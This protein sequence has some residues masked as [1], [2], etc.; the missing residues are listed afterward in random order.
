[1]R[2]DYV[3]YGPTGF[4]ESYIMCLPTDT[5]KDEARNHLMRNKAVIL[6]TDVVSGK[7]TL[8]DLARK[9]VPLENT[10]YLFSVGG[11][12]ER[13]LRRMIENIDLY[14]S[15]DSEDKSRLEYSMVTVSDKTY[16]CELYE[17]LLWRYSE[18]TKV[19]ALVT[20]GIDTQ[21]LEGNYKS[22]HVLEYLEACEEYGLDYSNGWN[23]E[24]YMELRHKTTS[25][26]HIGKFWSMY[27][28]MRLQGIDTRPT[29]V[30]VRELYINYLSQVYKY[31]EE[32]RSV[33]HMLLAE[34]LLYVGINHST[35]SE[36]L[37]RLHVGAL[38]ISSFENALE[39][40]MTTVRLEEV[41][42]L[43]GDLLNEFLEDPRE[44]KEREVLMGYELR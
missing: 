39:V 38:T 3:M 34:A 10:L 9:G 8:L 23:H 44:S 4:L 26:E 36:L 6:D 16:N 27:F 31:A 37:E 42:S 13:L 14:L 32:Y 33:R 30:D 22:P 17:T 19:M 28:K 24:R 7:Y 5:L 20:S 40:I 25:I 43:I 2:I 12:Q 1:M 18:P 21:F 15:T 41:I 35:V 29:N 11:D